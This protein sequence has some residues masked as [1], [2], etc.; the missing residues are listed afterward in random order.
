MIIGNPV[1]AVRKRKYYSGLFPESLLDGC[2]H[3]GDDRTA[4][5]HIGRRMGFPV[6]AGKAIKDERKFNC[7][8]GK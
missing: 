1:G 3:F 4:C 8:G 7:L 5:H 6:T 2:I